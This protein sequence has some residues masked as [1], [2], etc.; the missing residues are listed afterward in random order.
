[1]YIDV[2]GSLGRCD[3]NL[4]LKKR[5]LIVGSPSTA[6]SLVIGIICS[7]NYEDR[8]MRPTGHWSAAVAAGLRSSGFAAFAIHK[9]SENQWPHLLTSDQE[10]SHRRSSRCIKSL[11]LKLY[12]GR[13]CGIYVT[14]S[15]GI[16]FCGICSEEYQALCTLY[17]DCAVGYVRSVRVKLSRVVC[18]A[19][20]PF[21]WQWGSNRRK[22]YWRKDVSNVLH[23]LPTTCT[24]DSSFKTGLVHIPFSRSR[25]HDDR[26]R[27]KKQI[28]PRSD[29]S[30]LQ[31]RQ[32][33]FHKTKI[34]PDSEHLNRFDTFRTH[35]KSTSRRWQP[36]SQPC[37]A[38]PPR[39]IKL[40]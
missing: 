38:L 1:V 37:G 30:S 2:R 6:L 21:W 29:W 9:I 7:G 23:T 11:M 36:F 17:R 10:H 32:A 40:S 3:R 26:L 13:A 34:L 24:K 14:M 19:A 15:F 5:R 12:V 8:R 28:W 18:K 35:E 27:I 20:D 25:K 22:H 33:H 39:F 4:N 16:W 31:I